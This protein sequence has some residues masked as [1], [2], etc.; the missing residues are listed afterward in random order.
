MSIQPVGIGL[1]GAGAFGEFCL[2]AFSSNHELSIAAVCDTDEARA[3]H[4]ASIYN[5]QAYSSL[6]MMLK[7]T[8][9]EIVALNTPPV[10]HAEQGLAVLQAH[11]HLF[12][13]KPL[14]LT[15]EDGQMLVNAAL[16]NGV[17][18]TVDYVMRRNPLWNAVALLRE[19]GVFGRLLHMDLANHA[20]GLNLSREHWFW[21]TA[22]SGGIWVEHGVHFFD[23]FAWVAG[24][25]G[26]VT[27]AQVFHAADDRIDRVEAL[28]YY[29]KTAAH[30]YH[31]FTHSSATERTTARITFEKAYLTL[32]EWVPTVLE[33]ETT[34]PP[35]MITSSL[36]GTIHAKT[37]GEYTH[38]VTTIGQKGDVYRAAVQDGMHELA[39]AARDPAVK[40]NVTGQNAIDSLSMAIQA[41]N[42][43]TV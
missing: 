32:H 5:A 6:E 16:Q 34:I 23:I 17:L 13:E 29:G 2:K 39:L 21:D 15:L 4:F 18:L 31:G 36:P 12:C 22:K 26:E 27:A 28:A 8:R 37:S 14:A 40:L 11:K 38:L 3:Q 30:F 10:L 42:F 19:L 35:E 24:S 1:V 41:A 43:S 7:D 25:Q 20:A 9:V 33:I